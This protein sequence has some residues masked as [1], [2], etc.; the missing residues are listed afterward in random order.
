[1]EDTQNNTNDPQDE[2]SA[3]S[4]DHRTEA[5]PSEEATRAAD[6]V[7]DDLTKKCEEY[8]SGW[9]RALADYANLKRESERGAADIGKY[10]SAGVVSAL[11]PI[12]DSFAKA[13]TARPANDDTAKLAQWADGIGHIKAQLDGAMTK[14]GLT[15]IEAAHVPFDP[16]QHEAMMMEPPTEF[17]KSGTVIRVLESGYKMHDRVLRPAKVVV[18]E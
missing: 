16:V 8:L 2:V 11:L 10:A 13:H 5:I 4:D 6:P 15:V 14:L 12:I 18:A 9:Q 17:V 7:A 3:G 1:M